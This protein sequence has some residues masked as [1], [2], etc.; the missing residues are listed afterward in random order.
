MEK[1]IQAAKAGDADAFAKL[2][3]LHMQSLYKVAKSI[4]WSDEDIADVIQETI[5]G[6][7]RSLKDLKETRYFK[8]WMTRILIN[9]CKDHIRKEQAM[10]GDEALFGL[11]E[12]EDG[13][14]NVEWKETLKLLDEKYRLVMILYYIEGFKTKEISQIIEMPEATVRTRLARGRERLAAIYQEKGD[15]PQKKQGRQAI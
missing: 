2:M 13:F 9:K 12:K 6:C 8:T 10:F 7:W 1:L 11:S 14:E 4:L 15:F 5:F 3:Q